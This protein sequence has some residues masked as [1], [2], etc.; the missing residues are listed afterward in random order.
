MVFSLDS[1]SMQLSLQKQAAESI[2]NEILN[3]NMEFLMNTYMVP[4]VKRAA[5]AAN[6]PEGFVLGITFVRT[7]SNEGEVINTWGS[8][9]LPLAKWFNYGTRDHGS[10]GNWP[11]RWRSKQTGVEIFAQYVRGV[12]QTLAMEI[13]IILGTNRLKQE[14]PRFVEDR[15]E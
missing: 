12:P 10:K 15:L 6:V 8:D 1:K 13:G 9:D 2:V 11:L 14:V 7:G 3:E 4:E 5:Q